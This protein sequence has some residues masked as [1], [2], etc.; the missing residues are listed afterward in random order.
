MLTYSVSIASDMVIVRTA[1][2]VQFSDQQEAS[3]QRDLCLWSL[4]SSQK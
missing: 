1:Y 3:R 2:L 4:A